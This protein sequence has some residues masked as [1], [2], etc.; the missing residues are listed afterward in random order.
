MADVSQPGANGPDGA[1]RHGP[2]GRR[3]SSFRLTSYL[4][5]HRMDDDMLKCF[6]LCAALAALGATS[7]NAQEREAVLQRAEVPALVSNPQAD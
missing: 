2:F 6:M 5:R 1:A 3:G 7:I 4:H